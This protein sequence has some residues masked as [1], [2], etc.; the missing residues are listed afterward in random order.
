MLAVVSAQPLPFVTEEDYLTGELRSEVKHEYY[1]GRVWA[2]A[3][4]TRAHELVAGNLF[5][6]LW[7]HLRGSGCR[8]FKS[9]MKV[10]L[11]LAKQPLFYYPD[12]MVS[13][14]PADRHELYSDRPKLII[15]V[16]SG[17]EDKDLVEKLL[18]YQRIPSLEEYVVASPR[19]EQPAVYIFRKADNW[20]PAETHTAMD[21]EIELRSVGLRVRVAEL[22]AL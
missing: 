17:D 16:L 4:A 8:V 22:F 15:E 18:A 10:R 13:C 7:N 14:D 12:V 19:A 6:L 20:E 11:A 1:H 5:A 3:G 2:M 9:D 21:A